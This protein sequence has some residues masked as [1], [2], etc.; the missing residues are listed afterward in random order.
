[1]KILLA[2]SLY[3]VISITAPAGNWTADASKA[4]ISFAVD[5]PFGMVHGTFSGL[6]SAF[7]FS[8]NDLPGS[9]LTATVDPNTVS[10]GIGLRNT[11]LRNEE[12][13]LNTKK[14]PEI[15]FSSRKIEK[16]PA[17]Y[18]I[19]GELT[20]KG[21]TKSIKIPLTFAPAGNIGIFKGEFTIQRMDY[22]IGKEGG[23]IGSIITIQLEVPVKK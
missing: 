5:G 14:Y 21:I 7:Q 20:L 23:S 10:S 9:S 13:F 22:Q 8:E 2:I 19:S 11:H 16:T 3:V 18:L 6:Q 1:M 12:Q 4:K 15:R 17:G